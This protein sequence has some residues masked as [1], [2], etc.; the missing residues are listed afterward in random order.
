MG[1]MPC[2]MPCLSCLVSYASAMPLLVG[3]AEVRDGES[4]R[5]R[6]EGMLRERMCGSLVRVVAERVRG[7]M[8]VVHVC[9]SRNACSGRRIAVDGDGGSGGN[10]SDAGSDWE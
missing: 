5:S 4:Q 6:H 2:L 3:G 10:V 1:A 7:M 9:V 8:C